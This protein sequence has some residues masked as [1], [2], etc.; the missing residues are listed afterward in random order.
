[1]YLYK[2]KAKKHLR[3]IIYYQ[4]RV[5]DLVKGSSCIHFFISYLFKKQF[6]LFSFI[7]SPAAI[8][9]QRPTWTLEERE[10]DFFVRGLFIFL[11]VVVPSPKIVI[12]L[13]LPMKNFTVKENYIGS[14]VSETNTQL[15][16][17][18]YRTQTSCYF[19]VRIIHSLNQIIPM[20]RGELWL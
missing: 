12:I 9:P 7:D 20:F 17:K 5:A 11:R 4:S 19:Y 16:R 8:R 2:L 13:G 14:R 1:M 18:L 6:F 10:R 15:Y 3:I